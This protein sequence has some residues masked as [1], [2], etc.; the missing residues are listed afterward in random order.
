V[1]RSGTKCLTCDRA[2][3]IRYDR[4]GAQLVIDPLPKPGGDLLLHAD[5]EHATRMSGGMSDGKP[6]YAAHQCTGASS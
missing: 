1:R 2:V 6:R 3:I 5:G 4:G